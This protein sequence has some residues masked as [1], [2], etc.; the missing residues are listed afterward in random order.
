M[1]MSFKDHFSRLAGDYVAYRPTQPSAAID[2]V[3]GLA[4]R[5]GVAW[6]CAT[7]SGQAAVGLASHFARVIATDASAAQIAHAAPHPRISFHVAPAEASGIAGGIVD[8]VTVAQAAHWLDLD[9]FYRE[10]RRVAAPEA[11]I[12]LWAYGNARLDAPG[13]DEALRRF[14]RETVGPYWPPERRLVDEGYR[15]I[16]FPFAEVR[17]PLF[18]LERSWTLAELVG[19]LRTWSATAR[20]AEARGHDPVQALE[21]ELGAAWG[22][23]GTRRLVRWPLA[24]RAGRVA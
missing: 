5:R 11:A 4:P 2:F 24:M 18:T 1:T 19:Y 3:A 21:A 14:S 16:P 17:P 7:G 22:D 23:P 15:T 9:A 8:L 13:L 20:Y 6:D 12:A 10:V